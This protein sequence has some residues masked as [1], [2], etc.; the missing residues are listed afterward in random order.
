MVEVRLSEGRNREIRRV[1][2]RLG[3]KVRRLKRVAIGP[4]ADR[5]LKIGNWRIL[6]DSEVSRLRAAGQEPTDPPKRTTAR[7]KRTQKK[8]KSSRRQ[9]GRQGTT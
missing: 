8:A 9:Q 5:G 2:A 6:T 7:P 4:I 1:M 3:L